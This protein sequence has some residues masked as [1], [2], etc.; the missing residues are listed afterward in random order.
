MNQQASNLVG[1]SEA[2]TVVLQT[3][4]TVSGWAQLS[5]IHSFP[6]ARHEQVGVL[7]LDP[8]THPLAPG[9]RITISA[10]DTELGLFVVTSMNF[11]ADAGSEPSTILDIIAA[12]HIIE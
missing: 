2:V 1:P 3:G 11:R 10:G 8:G 5:R 6:D 12:K 4:E 7:E 9:D